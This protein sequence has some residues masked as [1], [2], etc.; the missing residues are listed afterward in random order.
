M[1]NL[2]QFTAEST[3]EVL[4]L[5]QDAKVISSFKCVVVIGG[6]SCMFH[7]PYISHSEQH[8]ILG[9]ITKCSR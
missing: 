8:I 1:F 5:T 3:I 7:H 2:D 9:L 6:V 4:D